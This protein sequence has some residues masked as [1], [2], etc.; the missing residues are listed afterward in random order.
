MPARGRILY[1]R[2][3][4]RGMLGI[5]GANWARAPPRG[6]DLCWGNAWGRLGHET[7]CHTSRP[8]LFRLLIPSAVAVLFAI[9]DTRSWR[10]VQSP[11]FPLERSLTDMVVSC[12]CFVI[13]TMSETVANRIERTESSRAVMVW[14]ALEVRSGTRVGSKRS[15]CL[16]SENISPSKGRRGRVL[17]AGSGEAGLMRWGVLAD[18]V[19]TRPD[20]LKG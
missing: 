7:Q 20:C 8:A 15:A 11:P 14:S 12:S 10:V 5:H 1:Q 9:L 4:L 18:I 13:A 6:M 17:P 2:R 19:W 16:V 3:L